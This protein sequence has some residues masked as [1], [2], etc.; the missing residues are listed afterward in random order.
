MRERVE[1]I[2]LG[3]FICGSILSK[4]PSDK[5]DSSGCSDF[6]AQCFCGP[7]CKAGPRPCRLL[8]SEG[9]NAIVL[10]HTGV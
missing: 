3:T 1:G 6:Q 8:L 7:S 5:K 2:R 10:H 9:I 4:P